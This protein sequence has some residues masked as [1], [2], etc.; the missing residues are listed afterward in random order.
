[1]G[2]QE[3]ERRLSVKM[4]IISGAHDTTRNLRVSERLCCRFLTTEM[5]GKT[6]SL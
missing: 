4:H 1:M 6:D 2:R 5:V 3:E